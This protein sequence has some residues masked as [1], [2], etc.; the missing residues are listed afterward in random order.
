MHLDTD[1]PVVCVGGSAGSLEAY[2]EL[3]SH[4]PPDLGVAVVLV[5]HV[6]RFA[7]S[8]HIILS[9]FTSMPV[10]LITE[11]VLIEPN[12]IYV[13]PEN[14]DLHIFEGAFRLRPVSKP[15]G[16]PDVIT[17]FLRSLPEHWMG[18]LIAII[19]SEYGSDG[20]KALCE[21]KA[22]RWLGSVLDEPEVSPHS[23]SVKVRTFVRPG[24]A[25]QVVMSFRSGID[26][27]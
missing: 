4:L 22:V 9:R 8:L 27:W 7:T 1:F 25:V 6:R 26:R 10:H 3:L 12:H 11:D 23:A 14:R 19:V 15:Y 2:S 17:I 20:S 18:K 21:I 13:I 5:N 16:W 24:R